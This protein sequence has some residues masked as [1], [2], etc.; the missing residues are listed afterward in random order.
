MK[1]GYR[2]PS[3]KKSISAK[4]KGRVTRSMKST[5]NPVY[6]IKGT[7]IVN[8]PKKAVYNQIYDKTSYDALRNIRSQTN[9]SSS[10]SSSDGSAGIIALF[11]TIILVILL[12]VFIF[13]IL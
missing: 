13:A 7:G 6:G 9:E 8:N 4:T 3:I 12:A 1:F 11:I 10:S 2:K 5:V